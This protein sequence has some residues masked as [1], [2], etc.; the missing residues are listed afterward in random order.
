[1]ATPIQDSL[2]AYHPGVDI[3]IPRGPEPVRVFQPREETETHPAPAR[4]LRRV[5]AYSLDP[6]RFTDGYN[7][8][9]ARTLAPAEMAGRIIDTYA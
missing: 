2:V 5:H 4:R 8:S 7:A 3:I 6:T 1:M 9:G